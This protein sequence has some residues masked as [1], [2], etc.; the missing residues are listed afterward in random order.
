MP[1]GTGS[2]ESASMPVPRGV[3]RARQRSTSKGYLDR[4][5]AACVA[6][7]K[8]AGLLERHEEDVQPTQLE[9]QVSTHGVERT[10]SGGTLRLSS[11]ESRTGSSNTGKRPQEALTA[12]HYDVAEP[13]LEGTAAR[14]TQCSSDTGPASSHASVASQPAPSVDSHV[15]NPQPGIAENY[16]PEQCGL[17]MDS[18]DERI[19]VPG[20]AAA[21]RAQLPGY[22]PEAPGRAKPLPQ[23]DVPVCSPQTHPEGSHASS[24]SPAQLRSP[25]PAAGM[26]AGS[27]GVLFVQPPPKTEAIRRVAVT[28]DVPKDAGLQT[29]PAQPY[30][31]SLQRLVN[32]HAY[33]AAGPI[34][35]GHAAE[36]QQPLS[37][38]SIPDSGPAKAVSLDRL[39]SPLT[40][41]EE[42][43]AKQFW[44]VQK[45]VVE[46]PAQPAQRRA[47]SLPQ[48][49]AGLCSCFNPQAQASPSEPVVVNLCMTPG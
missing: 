48:L 36:Q 46:I 37:G 42:G 35:H 29:L 8:N 31:S 16:G 22:C 2:G 23:A 26:P 38:A 7:G 32:L 13:G 40:S 9:E 25:L 41:V 12:A 45:K 11:A 49:L 1:S 47:R 15:S 5:A 21:E 39:R 14:V 19:D 43:P 6:S 18:V 27:A 24:A 30:Y 33:A 28:V 10:R 3:A 34:R 44:E 20:L 4:Y 17:C